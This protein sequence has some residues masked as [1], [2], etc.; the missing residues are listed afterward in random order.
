MKF[1]RAGG[2][3]DGKT[4]AQER[5]YYKDIAKDQSHTGEKLVKVKEINVAEDCNCSNINKG[6]ET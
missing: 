1:P 4:D 5:G 2:G 3:V 6:T